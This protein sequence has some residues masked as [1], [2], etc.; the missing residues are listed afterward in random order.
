M[1]EDTVESVCEG[2]GLAPIRSGNLFVFGM[3]LHGS[4]SSPAGTAPEGIQGPHSLLVQ[5]AAAAARASLP[6]AATE[7]LVGQNAVL[8]IESFRPMRHVTLR[9]EPGDS[10][11]RGAIEA[12]LDRRLGMMGAP[13]HETGMWLTLIGYTLL[14]VALCTGFVLLLRLFLV[15]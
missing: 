1:V 4:P 2:F 13:Y 15:H 12:E 7:E 5:R 14:G 3:G 9:W 11:L 10:P 8:E 6:P